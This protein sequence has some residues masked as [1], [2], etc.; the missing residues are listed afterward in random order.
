MLLA[1]FQEKKDEFII[2]ISVE[3]NL[4]LN[5]QLAYKSDLRQFIQFWHTLTHEEQEKLSLRQIIERYLVSLFY[6]KIDKSS[7]ARKFSCFRSF[8]LFLRTQGIRLNLKLKTPRVEKK[9]PIFLTVDEMFYLLDNVKLEDL[10]TKFPHRDSAILELLYATGIR[11]S[12][13][14]AIRFCDVDM[15]LKNI[16]IFG[17]G[18]KERFVLFNDKAHEKLVSYLEHER[19]SVHHGKEPLF[20]GTTSQPIKAPVVQGIIKMFR[21]FLKIDRPI[22]PHKIRHSFATHMV[23][24]GADLRVV[25]ELLGHRSL[26]STERYTHVSLNDLARL[27]DALHPLNKLLIKKQE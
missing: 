22:T 18:N 11:C 24:Q 1:E 8:E 23:S 7:I 6:K 16:R 14:I 5:T 26:S 13:L 3:K 12:E 20:V 9:L 27:C 17:K 21:S 15:S 2:Y 25:Q 19:P 4:S 10:P